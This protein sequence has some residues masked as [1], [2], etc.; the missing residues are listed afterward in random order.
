MGARRVC[1]AYDSAV[2]IMKRLAL[3]PDAIA[4]ARRLRRE[5]TR[6]ERNLWRAMRAGIPNAH[7]RKQVPMGRYTADFACHHA[8]LIIEVDGGQ[9]G[10]DK[11]IAYDA[12]RTA[13]LEAEG[14]KTLRF[15]NSDIDHNLEAVLIMIAEA[16][17]GRAEENIGAQTC[18]APTLPSPHGG[19]MT[20]VH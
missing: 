13:F 19:G 11:G 12:E 20:G 16:L 6:Q 5:M 14:Y 17:S 4:Y 2:L 8:K 9:H 1:G 10:T 18:A 15:W 7:F 3:P